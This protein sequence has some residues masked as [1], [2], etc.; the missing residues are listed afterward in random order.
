MGPSPHQWLLKETIE[1]LHYR[2]KRDG[3]MVS[4]ESTLE[5][6]ML[7]LVYHGTS[8]EVRYVDQR[9][10][11]YILEQAG[12]APWVRPPPEPPKPAPTSPQEQMKMQQEERGDRMNPDKILQHLKY[13][14]LSHPRALRH[15]EECL[16]Y[17]FMWSI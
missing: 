10:R 16:H 5:K 6:P 3:Y 11:R 8:G 17:E 13:V 15:M 14:L 9:T 2:L 12:L 7:T 1:A 4:S